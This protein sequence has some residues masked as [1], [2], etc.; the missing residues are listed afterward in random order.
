MTTHITKAGVIGAGS[1]GS[2]IA[3]LLASAGIQVVLLDMNEDG[4][5]KAVELQRKRKGFYH[6]DFADNV[7]AGSDFSLLEGCEWVIEA[8]FEDLEAKHNL[9]RDIEPHLGADTIL[10]SNTSTLPL[11]RLREGVAA[12]RPFAI[13]HFFNPPKVMRLVELIASGETERRLRATIEQQLGKVAL[14]CRDT[15]G[16][17]ANRLGCYWMAAGAGIAMRDGISYELA[18][19][20]FGRA[21]GIPRTGVFGLLDYIGLQLVK[22]IWGSLED[23]LP[24][25]D[26]LFR[27][28]LGSNEFIAG[29]V[30]RG[31]TGRT[32]EGGFYKGRD[33]VIN[34]D[35]EYVQRTQPDDEALAARDPRTLLET[36]SPGG[37]YA[38][39]LFLETLEYCCVVA[40]EIAD[41]VGL[42]DEGLKLGFGWKKGIFE[43]A[44]VVGVKWLAQQYETAPALLESAVKAGGFYVDGKV[45]GSS[46]VL[47]QLPAREGVV[48]VAGL[49]AKGRK[50]VDEETIQV[51]LLDNGVAIAS[52]KTP[53]NSLPVPALK[54]LTQAVND[55]E[56]LGIRSLVIGSDETRAFSAGAHLDSLASA[57][58]SGD[59]AAVREMI[60]SGSILMRTL[61]FAPIPVVGAV[62]GVALG[63]GAE[64][65]LA[66]DARVIH[67]DTQLGFPER[68]VGLY[69]AWTGTVSSLENML[70][71]GK[72]HQE[73]FDFI[74]QA[75]PA[76]NAFYARE[77]G[78]LRPS[79]E[80][81][82]SVDHVLSRA[83]DLAAE[84]AE[85]YEAPQEPRL[86]LAQ[87][88]EINLE[89]ASST[90][91]VILEALRAHYTGDGEVSHTELAES[92]VDKAVPVILN[93]PNA[94]RARHYADH[95]KPLKN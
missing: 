79:D 41:H 15:P 47:T 67:A 31:L 28:P 32:G 84:L 42:L 62:K 34:E 95:R 78:L 57:A 22:P 77:A 69:P 35:Y 94:E 55:A 14:E 37:R 63:G 73:A 23:A 71:A 6:P 51:L 4:A 66:C 53:L 44:D 2:G 16:F 75:V 29:L 25:D 54:A 3:A 50:V 81:L 72:T 76:P 59:E 26:L 17:I 30:E 38:K 7:T 68:L 92:E 43:L 60:E 11:E 39:E 64:L 85:G 52:L 74:A 10:S 88:L 61:R 18:D 70:A 93:G 27:W 91:L 33:Q 87:D 56:S 86:P 40:P 80:I 49:E 12:E 36:D 9:Y 65:A 46:G 21:L 1:M 20:S 58:E 13:T 45:L 82:L 48:S 19:A 83:I 24:A 8:I 89:D 90:D 5:C